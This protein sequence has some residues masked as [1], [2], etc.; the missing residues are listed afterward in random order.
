M[1]CPYTFF[2]VSSNRP[3]TDADRGLL[4][5]QFTTITIS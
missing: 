3:P 4:N 2:N 1:M 5:Y